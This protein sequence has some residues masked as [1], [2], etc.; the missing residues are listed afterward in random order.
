MNINWPWLKVN[1]ENKQW[2]LIRI[3]EFIMILGS[4]IFHHLDIDS[5]IIV[6]IG[7]EWGNTAEKVHQQTLEVLISLNHWQL[8]W[9]RSLSWSFRWVRKSPFSI[10][11]ESTT[12]IWRSEC[13]SSIPDWHVHINI[14]CFWLT[15]NAELQ[16]NIWKSCW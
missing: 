12:N 11:G 10:P 16:W 13:V 15:E 8:E 7:N 1:K 2:G 4:P 3:W 14:D 5:G 9:C 6:D